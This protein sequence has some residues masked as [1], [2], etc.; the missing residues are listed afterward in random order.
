MNI[1]YEIAVV[2]QAL[3][4]IVLAT[5]WELGWLSQ[6]VPTSSSYTVFFFHLLIKTRRTPI[7]SVVVCGMSLI[8]PCRFVLHVHFIRK[9]K[10]YR[11]ELKN[12]KVSPLIMKGN[13]SHII[14][15]HYWTIFYWLLHAVQSRNSVQNG[16]GPSPLYPSW[17]YCYGRVFIIPDLPYPEL[18]FASLPLPFLFVED[19]AYVP[20]S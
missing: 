16:S 19:D 7:V 3:H 15:K 12:N 11:D 6:F 14:S 17:Q 10:I 4:N 5:V 18:L 8:G 13:V 1:T 2:N 9:T 20:V